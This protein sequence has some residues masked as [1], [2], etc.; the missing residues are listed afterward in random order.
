MSKFRQIISIFLIAIVVS[1][2]LAY[3]G[4]LWSVLD[5]S[6]G[7]NFAWEYLVFGPIYLAPFYAIFLVL[8]GLLVG[9]PTLG[10]LRHTGHSTNPRWLIPVG[11]ISGGLTGLFVFGAWLGP[12]ALVT[13]GVFGALGGMLSAA[14]WYLIVERHLEN[15]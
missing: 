4:G 13:G 6:V 5:G 1:A 14:A 2:A 9:L 10:V 7:S 3:M 15:A 11:L 8:G 12:A